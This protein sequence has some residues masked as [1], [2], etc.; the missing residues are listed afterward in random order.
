MTFHLVRLPTDDEKD[1]EANNE[2]GGAAD[3]HSTSK[4]DERWKQ[5]SGPKQKIQQCP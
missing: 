1:D 2:E 3:N 5:Q 4:V